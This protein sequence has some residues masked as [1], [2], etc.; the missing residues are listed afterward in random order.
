VQGHLEPGLHPHVVIVRTCLTISHH[1]L[2]WTGKS[3]VHVDVDVP[4][5]DVVVV[6]DDNYDYDYD[7]DSN[8]DIR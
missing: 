3:L 6:V 1:H 2:S 8:T 4:G 7:Y 5:N